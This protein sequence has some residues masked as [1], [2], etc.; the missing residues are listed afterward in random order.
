MNYV[1]KVSFEVAN[2][3]EEQKKTFPT[4]FALVVCRPFGTLQSTARYIKL[5]KRVF[6]T[7]FSSLSLPS[8]FARAAQEERGERRRQD[9]GRGGS[10]LRGADPGA[11]ASRPGLPSAVR[12]LPAHR[13]PLHLPLLGRRAWENPQTRG[14]DQFRVGMALGSKR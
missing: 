14:K 9:V 4:A 3:T 5:F 11:A 2:D 6:Q 12:L 8:R 10:A 13:G 1:G 7:T